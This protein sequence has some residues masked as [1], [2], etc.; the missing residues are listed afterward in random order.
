MKKILSIILMIPFLAL[1]QTQT[2]N[3]IK[4]TIYKGAG[5]TL[6][7]VQVNYFDGLGR[8]IQQV[9][10]AQ[11]GTGNDIITH[12]EY[13]ALGRQAKDFLPYVNGAPSLNYNVSANTQVGSFYNNTN[14]GNTLNPFSQK[15]FEASPFNRVLKQGAPGNAWGLGSGHE[16]KMDY[17]TNSAAEVKYYNATISWDAAKGL[18]DLISIVQTTN[19]DA[20][21]LYKTITKDE[22]WKAADIDNNTTQE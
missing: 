10:H 17:Q 3:Y 11:S 7:V 14:Y 8:P 16:I 19:Y 9:A 5:A 15:E 13:D 4:T 6:P 21:Q 22:N 2:E 1:A 20:N 12:I 18:Y